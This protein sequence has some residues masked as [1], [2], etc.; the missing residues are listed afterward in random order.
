M[1]NTIPLVAISSTEKLRSHF[2]WG[3][4]FSVW[5]FGHSSQTSSKWISTAVTNPTLVRNPPNHCVTINL[6]PPNPLLSTNILHKTIKRQ[7]VL[8]LIEA[9]SVTICLFYH[10]SIPN[11]SS[12][13]SSSQKHNIDWFIHK[14]TMNYYQ[15]VYLLSYK[16]DVT[17][18]N[19]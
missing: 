5:V 19:V 10:L 2:S 18:F 17:F 16:K 14:P 3:N 7:A 15:A 9:L 11:C 1:W 4:Q 8:F 12:M 6:F 13:Y